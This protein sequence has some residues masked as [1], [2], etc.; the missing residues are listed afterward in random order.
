MK[1]EEELFGGWKG[2]GKKGQDRAMGDE[3]EQ[4]T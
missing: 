4:N 1:A 3:T 2:R